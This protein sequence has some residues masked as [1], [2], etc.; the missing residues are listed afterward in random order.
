MSTA[1]AVRSSILET[2][3]E[4]NIII[5]T[6]DLGSL[7]SVRSAAQSF[8]S[9]SSRLD[10]L[11]LNAGVALSAPETTVEGYEIQFGTNHV[12]H[13]LLTQLLL[14]TMLRTAS[15]NTTTPRIVVVAS[16][17]YKILTTPLDLPSEAMG[18]REQD[19]TFSRY[20]RSKLANI[21]FTSELSRRY[22]NILSVS[23][24]PGAVGTPVTRGFEASY[25][26]TSKLIKTFLLSYVFSTVQVGAR[27]QL[28]AATGNEVKSGA[29]YTPVGVEGGR[30]RMAKDVEGTAA[31]ELWDWTE[32][33]LR[34]HDNSDDKSGWP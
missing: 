1:K 14:P 15:T 5:L 4:A 34:K 9:D 13:A 8:I 3:P 19:W 12:G 29:Y 26:T 11:M 21:L 28:W 10:I 30:S 32:K 18:T 7:A 2:H 23:I 20:G 17:A 31:K 16:D 6:L 25:P 27:N 22:P 33:E 24:H